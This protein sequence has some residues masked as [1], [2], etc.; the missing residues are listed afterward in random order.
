MQSVEAL[1]HVS[2]GCREGTALIG[3]SLRPSHSVPEPGPFTSPATAIAAVNLVPAATNSLPVRRG[4]FD[5][6]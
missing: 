6:F 2:A 1:Q 4:D 3:W 5:R